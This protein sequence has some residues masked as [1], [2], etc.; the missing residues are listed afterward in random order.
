MGVVAIAAGNTGGKHFALHK[1]AVDV[2]FGIDLTVC[3][4][5]PRVQSG[6]QITI[7]KG[8]AFAIVLEHLRP[9]RMAG[10]THRQLLAAA[11]GP[12][13]LRLALGIVRPANALALV[14]KMGK[15]QR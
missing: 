7:G 3:M 5:E 14:E 15:P 9:P 10:R 4:V 8:L 13:S 1:R 12:A 2:H 6:R 11:I